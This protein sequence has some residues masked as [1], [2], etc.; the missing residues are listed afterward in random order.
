MAKC[1]DHGKTLRVT[2]SKI[3]QDSHIYASKDIIW[4][5][6]QGNRAAWK[7][8]VFAFTAYAISCF[9]KYNFR[10]MYTY[11]YIYIYT[12]T[13]VYV[14]YFMFQFLIYNICIRICIHIRCIHIC[15]HVYIYM[16]IYICTHVYISYYRI[17]LQT[18]IS[19]LVEQ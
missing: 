1:F 14:H 3:P 12:N 11:I 16:Y 6:F 9:E 2:H 8:N 18:S 5:G 13:Y 19:L 4:I 7:R 10:K 15:I 17:K